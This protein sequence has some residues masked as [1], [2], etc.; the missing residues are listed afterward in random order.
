M[1]LT[2]RQD[3][4]IIHEAG[5]ELVIYDTK[6]HRIHRLNAT[7]A[8]VWKRCNGRMSVEEITRSLQA[9]RN[10]LI[11]EQVV[12]HALQKLD[13]VSL[14]NGR[15]SLP[16]ETPQPTRR[17]IV[18]RFATM[19]ASL[20]ILPAIASMVVAPTAAQAK[21]PVL[22]TPNPG[23]SCA[24]QSGGNCSGDCVEST[25]KQVSGGGT[26]GCVA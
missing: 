25:C 20:L 15:L 9:E 24:G 10:S 18:R 23:P 7:V 12:W 5:D 11:D 14:L 1:L 26:C 3:G 17:D 2:A 16:A 8:F 21:L 4:L 22:R 19:G 6:K 13:K